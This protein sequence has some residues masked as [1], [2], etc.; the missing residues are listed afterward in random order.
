[1]IS[2]FLTALTMFYLKGVPVLARI[3]GNDRTVHPLYVRRM[4]RVLKAAEIDVLYSE[5]PGL[6]H[7]WW[8]TK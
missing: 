2:H 7:W 3:G 5:L 6:E 1:M 8:D 4:L